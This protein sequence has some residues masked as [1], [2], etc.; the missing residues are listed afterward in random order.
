MISFYSVLMTL[1]LFCALLLML[2][3][4]QRKKGY[5]YALS[6][7]NLLILCFHFICIKLL[8]AQSLESAVFY[9][10]IH[11]AI[12]LVVLPLFTYTFSS[13]T[14]F[15]YTKLLVK[16]ITVICSIFLIM[17]ALSTEPLRYGQV[18][19]LATYQT[20]F[21]DQA[22]VIV[23]TSSD[24]VV[25]FHS[26]TVLN[27]FLLLFFA[28]RFYMARKNLM[29]YAMIVCLLLQVISAFVGFKIDKLDSSLV[30]LGGM[31]LTFISI[32]SVL[33][34]SFSLKQ[35]TQ[36]LSEQTQRRIALETAFSRL[37][38]DVSFDSSD[39]FYVNTLRTL[40]EFS[41]A[42]FIL[43]GLVRT[44][45]EHLVDTIAVLKNGQL[46]PNFTYELA[47]SPCEKVY[48]KEACYFAKGVAQQFPTDLF[49]TEQHVESY[50]GMALLDQDNKPFGVIAM[51]FR[52]P[53]S[54]QQNLVQL[55]KVVSVRVSAE[56]RRSQLEQRLQKMAYFDYVSTLPNQASLVDE[57]N[58][59]FFECQKS[60]Q[61]AMLMLIDLDYF[62]DINRK[63]GFDV[64][65]QVI[66]QLGNRLANYASKDVFIARKSGDEFAVL[67][68]RINGEAHSVLEVHW[69]ALRA[70]IMQTC[71]IGN[72]QI[73]LQC[74]LGAVMFPQQ[75]PNPFNV[76]SCAEHAM[77]QAKAKGRNQF[78]MFDPSVLAELE[79]KKQLET[80]LKEALRKTDE[81]FVV[82]QP[83][84]HLDGKICGAEALIR[85]RTSTKAIISPA[86]F[87]PLA[88]ESGLIHAIGQ[89]VLHYVCADMVKWQAQGIE[90]PR[91]SINISATEFEQDGFVNK[92]LDL[93]ANCGVPGS[94]LEIEL[95]ETA[96]LHDSRR[97]VAELNRIKQ[98][99]VDIALDDFGTGY[100]SLSYLQDLPID[101]LKID[102]S[103]IDNLAS[104]R[105]AELV[106]AI[107]TI[108]DQ[109]GLSVVAEGTETKEQVD[110]L[111]A[112]GCHLF[113]GYY[114]SKPLPSDEFI[115]FLTTHSHR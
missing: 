86:Q 2:S 96:L 51:L 49:L 32:V 80:N 17:N 66:N 67:L 57:V 10:R 31:P 37:A 75:T 13:W 4:L 22:N 111:S 88:E 46:V 9:S 83:K 19:G 18:N 15:Q 12:I 53:L 97:V 47:G 85:W 16:F 100:S 61:Q 59:S 101:V 93:I 33:L 94:M 105:S 14:R 29:S 55:M 79:N 82:Y 65:D 114:F 74:S 70:I 21:S 63:F 104:M 77:Q 72:R 23:G 108:A 34:I 68:K 81:L 89:Y 115:A 27:V 44:P 110:S 1:N 41:H 48:S 45:D 36:Q 43:I 3:G 52:Q 58:R 56:L 8:T 106:K 38:E 35:K 11:T 62:G 76:M 54:N 7:L 98:S 91:I 107:I 95:T 87:I 112:M 24:A 26:L 5:F 42:D 50:I 28:V 78:A 40:Y 103:F 71:L 92:F 64:G 30:Y 113:Q 20:I 109:M 90:I 99:G 73:T 84:V 69:A 39:Q 60:G 102:K 25:L 6:V